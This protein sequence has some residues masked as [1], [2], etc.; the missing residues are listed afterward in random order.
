VQDPADLGVLEASAVLRQRSL[1]AVELLAA[2]ERRIAER[3]GGEPSFDGAPNAVN[4]WVRLY[5]E[6]AARQARAAD[7]RLA[8]EGSS[9]PALC[10]IPLALKDLFAVDGL[11]LTASS[12][13]LDDNVAQGS[14]VA[15]ERLE[16]AGMVLV[17]H[18]HTHEFAA[19]GTTDQVGNP[20][21]LD[22][23]VGGS[24]GGSAAALAAGMVPAAL[25]TDTAGSLRIPA[26]LSGVSSVKPTHGRVPIGGIVPLAPSLDHAGPM[27]RSLADCGALLAAL[28]AGGAEPT[29]VMPPPAPIGSIPVEART[30]AR[31]LDG[32]TVALTDRTE[33]EG[34][35]PD[36]ADGLGAARDACEELG[37]T[38]VSLKAAPDISGPDFSAVFLSEVAVYH[39]QHA[40]AAD[41]YRTSIRELVEDSRGFGAVDAY[42]RAQAR[43]A[44]MTAAW[45]RW[46]IDNAVDVLLEPTVPVTAEPRGTGYD[47][48]SLAGQGDPLIRFTATW[49]ATGFPVAALPAGLGSR[50]GMPVGVS[51]IAPRGAEATV[52][53]VGIDLQEHALHP[54]G[55]AS[56][57]PN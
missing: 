28:A 31:P 16:E 29:P 44:E 24:S 38:I 11:P 52:I 48:G 37:A 9:A 10:G 41:G 26:A 20:R 13:V 42:L 5:P 34:L 25:G 39:A 30:S 22:R 57:R 55:I 19:G 12:R 7:E 50:S 32:V 36:V 54:L 15:W 45:E 23:S 27:A 14:C 17:G 33:A 21:A 49:D 18:T 3:N 47:S 46:F 1:S 43:R 51:L 6:V 56:P 2:C 40:E 35:E 53:Q 4:A 8:R